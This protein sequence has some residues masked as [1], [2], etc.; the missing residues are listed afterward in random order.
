MPRAFRAGG[1]PVAEL[2]QGGMDPRPAV[3]VVDGLEER[4]PCLAVGQ[5]RHR[6]W[7][8]RDNGVH[9]VGVSDQHLERYQ[10][11]RAVT[12]HDRRLPA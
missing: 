4:H 9:H 8:V 1:D 12:D 3:G 6:R 2:R 7:L 10:G 5:Q 11:A